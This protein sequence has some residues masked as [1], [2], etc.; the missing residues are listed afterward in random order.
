MVNQRNTFA[1]M[2]WFVF[3]ATL[4]LD[5]A[6]AP[7]EEDRIMQEMD[8]IYTRMP[9]YGAPRM[10]AELVRRG[11]QVGEKRLRRLMK[12]MG[13]QAIYPKP[14]LSKPGKA[15]RSAWTDA[16]GRMTTYSSRGSGDR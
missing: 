5:I 9:F 3:L 15:S 2:A 14:N 16:V 12:E 6:P 11:Y 1:L 13:I 10:T 7:E 4:A 8:E